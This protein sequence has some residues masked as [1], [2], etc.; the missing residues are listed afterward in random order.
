MWCALHRAKEEEELLEAEREAAAAAEYQALLAAQD[1]ERQAALQAMYAK[2]ATRAIQAGKQV[3][4]F[5]GSACGGLLPVA[6]A[7][8]TSAFLNWNS[9]T[10]QGEGCDVHS[11]SCRTL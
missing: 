7:P 11:R 5:A 1:A 9:F 6:E 2:S 3:L 8:G 10:V 4:L